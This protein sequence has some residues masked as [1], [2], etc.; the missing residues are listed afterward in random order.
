MKRLEAALELIR[1]ANVLADIGC[2]HGLLPL[3][4]LESG[5]AKK[6]Y[7][8]DISAK[9]LEK[10]QT[11]LSG[12]DDA[13]CIVSDGLDAVPRDF[14]TVTICGMGAQTMLGIISRSGTNAALVLQPQ[15]QAHEVRKT[16]T[17]K[18]GYKL[19]EEKLAFERGRYYP[20]MRFEK[21]EGRLSELETMFGINVSHPDAVLVK[22]CEKLKNVYERLPA[23]GKN[24]RILAAAVQVLNNKKIDG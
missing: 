2:D 16:L 15:T 11:A 23:D 5:R 18:L 1:G 19:T 12:R 21:G 6:A 22:M 7:A 24:R 4:A 3:A 10:A 20:V 8:C 14:D 17:E 13:V 9:S